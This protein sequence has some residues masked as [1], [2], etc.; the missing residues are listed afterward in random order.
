MGNNNLQNRKIKSKQKL[1]S[2]IANKL[3]KSEN[4]K[5]MGNYEQAL[6]IAKSVLIQDP[7]CLEAAEEVV[8][9]LL[10]LQDFAEAEK[11][12]NFVLEKNDKSYIGN[13]ALGFI[14][15]TDN[16]NDLAIG[17]LK[18]A[19]ELSPNNPEILRCLG[20][21][22]FH[23]ENKLKGLVTLERAL[24]LRSEDPLILC[25]LGVC[26]LQ[27]QIFSKAINLFEQAL[28]IDST[29]ERAQD[30]LQA[31]KSLEKKLSN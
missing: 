23:V 7:S 6:R 26:L 4:A 24:N 1:S 30:C 10:S 19:N 25:D 17:Y 11:V 29:N 18:K 16:L 2:I 12:A 21:A 3:E 15:L 20:W 28:E 9:N 31:A 22:T 14:Y 5:V 13:Y 8:D 27:E